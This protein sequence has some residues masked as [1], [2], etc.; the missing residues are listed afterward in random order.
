[1]ILP[2]KLPESKLPV[3]PTVPVGKDQRYPVAAPA[4]AVAAGNTAG[5]M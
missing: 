5:A 2:F 3:D 1:M 4:V